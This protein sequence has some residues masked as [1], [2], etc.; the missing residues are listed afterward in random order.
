M[1]IACLVYSYNIKT[2]REW[3]C[4]IPS[5]YLSRIAKNL[6]HL[7]SCRDIKSLMKHGWVPNRLIRNPGYIYCLV[8][9]VAGHKEGHWVTSLLKWLLMSSLPCLHLTSWAGLLIKSEKDGLRLYNDTVEL[10]K[11]FPEWSFS[12]NITHSPSPEAIFC[13]A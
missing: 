1:Y 13:S 10:P 12:F 2:Q 11:M 9:T 3:F 4:S 5:S 6:N 7:C 8:V